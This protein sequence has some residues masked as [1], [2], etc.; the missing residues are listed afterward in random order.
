EIV[1]EAGVTKPSLY[2][3]FKSK[4]DLVAACLL[5]SAEEGRTAVEAAVAAAGPCP[6]DRLRAIIAHFAGKIGCPEF[7]GCLISNV[8]VELPDASHPGRIILQNCKTDLRAMMVEICRELPVEEPEA[9]ADGL[10]LVIEGAM[11]THH[12]FGKQGPALAIT[13]T[14]EQLI[15][16]NLPVEWHW[17]ETQ[18]AN[19]QRG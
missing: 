3:A 12:I 7:R 9:L 2:R 11:A 5:E 15:A 16:G 1:C 10:L 13:R 8:A 14:C 17:K 19:W 4:D 6:R 18:L